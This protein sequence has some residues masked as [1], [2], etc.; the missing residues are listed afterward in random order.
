MRFRH[1]RHAAS[2]CLRFGFEDWLDRS[3]VEACDVDDGGA[4]E[5]KVAVAADDEESCEARRS[6]EYAGNER[7]SMFPGNVGYPAARCCSEGSVLDVV[8]IG[9]FIDIVVLY[10]VPGLTGS[11]VFGNVLEQTPS[12]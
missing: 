8:D 5:T 3:G 1:G 4:D 11:E 2:V 6:G 9:V 10:W 12:F 7:A